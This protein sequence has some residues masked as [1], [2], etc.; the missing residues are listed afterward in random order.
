MR[1]SLHLDLFQQREDHAA[2]QGFAGG[3][4]LGLLLGMVLALLF[5]PRRGEDVRASVV[6]T[7][8]DVKLRT[9]HL[10][11]RTHSEPEAAK[12]FGSG[13]AIEREIESPPTDA[14]SS[15]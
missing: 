4:A 7:A 6:A 14:T 1:D 12:D 13:A 11:E 5:A 3:L 9:G 15:R 10:L 8:H 2:T